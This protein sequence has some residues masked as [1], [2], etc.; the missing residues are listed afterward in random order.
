MTCSRFAPFRAPGA[1][2]R[3]L[4]LSRLAPVALG[5][6]VWL[7]AAP[8]ARA[9]DGENLLRNP[10][11]EE[12]TL[13]SPAAWDTTLSDLPTVRFAW[14]GQTAHSG[15]R[16]LYVINTSDLIPLWHNW[17]QTLLGA[18]DLGGKELTLRAWVKTR[19]VT[20]KAYL[21]L[22][23][24]RDT[25]LI[26]AAKAAVPRLEMRPRMGIKPADDPQL[27]LGWARKQI[28]GDHPEWTP[29]E[30]RLYI[31]PSTN[32]VIVRGGLLGIGEAW[33]DDFSLT[34]APARPERP[35]PLGKNLLVDPGFEGNLDDWDFSMPPVEGLRIHVDAVAHSGLQS[36][37]IE[38]QRRWRMEIWSH[39]F[40]VFN[41]RALSGKRVRLSGWY[42]SEDLKNTF[43]CFSVSA[44]GMYGTFAPV[45]S[46]A[47]SG[48]NDWTFASYEID[49]PPDTYTVWV[50]A[51]LN[52]GAGKVW[53]DDLR[54][55]VLGDSPKPAAAGA[56]KKRSAGR[57]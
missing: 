28:S 1:M 50:R 46:N 8:A 22:Q 21:L 44:T 23:A 7:L 37:L 52:T 14:D 17:S 18:N 26:E 13:V 6:V 4:L 10:S 47:W 19:A 32:V 35:F 39:V 51:V 31:P 11:A 43:A 55:E 15:S 16:S 41:T 57:K 40:Q 42:K 24:Y 12:G 38:S 27:E 3:P 36:C 30:A 29:I 9:A 45:V 53:F 48:T 25:V 49:I 54:F 20:G 5:L 56:T 33:F 2:G 34:A